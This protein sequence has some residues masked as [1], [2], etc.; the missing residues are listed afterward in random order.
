MIVTLE[1]MECVKQASL[2]K[3]QERRK[4]EIED[5]RLNTMKKQEELLRE[6]KRKHDEEKN[7]WDDKHKMKAETIEV[8]QERFNI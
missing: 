7:S 4:K 2:R 8:L 5:E 3:E 6:K 1:M